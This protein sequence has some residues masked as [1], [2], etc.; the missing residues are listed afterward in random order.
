M[1]FFCH[2]ERL[3]S[4]GGVSSSPAPEFFSRTWPLPHYFC[5][6]DGQAHH[7]L[8]LVINTSQNSGLKIAF[9]M[10]LLLHV[11]TILLFLYFI[12]FCFMCQSNG[13]VPCYHS[14]FFF[15]FKIIISYLVSFRSLV[16]S[17]FHS[18]VL[19]YPPQFSKQILIPE[20]VSCS[21]R[22]SL[23]SKKSQARSL[24]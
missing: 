10:K 19:C 8:H 1:H 22:I 20:V 7:W 18:F 6:F 4:S 5:I 15:F 23:S 2:K 11:N 21:L 9:W 3:H 24:I 17:F 16:L 13:L 14:F 12:I